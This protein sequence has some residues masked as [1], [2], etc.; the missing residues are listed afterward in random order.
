MR[1]AILLTLLVLV[2]ATAWGGGTPGSA[3]PAA[4]GTAALSPFRP[5]DLT[6]APRFASTCESHVICRYPFNG[7]LHCEG[8]AYCD[9]G[10]T[11]VDCDGQLQ[12]C[13]CGLMPPN[14]CP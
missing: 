3:P 4:V 9:S 6:P 8:D 5:A 14:Y 13:P 12:E 1:K 11:W 10:E 2:T 7:Y